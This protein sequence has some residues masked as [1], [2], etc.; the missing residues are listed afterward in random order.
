MECLVSPCERNA[1]ESM[2]PCAVR[3]GKPVDGPTRCMSQI[4]PGN[5]GVVAQPDEFRHQR[6]AGAGGGGH[7]ARARPACAQHHADGGEFVFRLHDGE[8]RF[9]VRADAETFM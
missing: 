4:T 7:G 8:G 3:V 5:L 6:N 9:A 2:S 1:D